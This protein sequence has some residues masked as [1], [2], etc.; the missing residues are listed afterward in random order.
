MLKSEQFED[1]IGS[2]SLMSYTHESSYNIDTAKHFQLIRLPL[3]QTFVTRMPGIT[4]CLAWQKEAPSPHATC[5]HL[6]PRVVIPI[7]FTT[8]TERLECSSSHLHA[9]HA[10]YCQRDRSV[11]Y[12]ILADHAAAPASAKPLSRARLRA[13]RS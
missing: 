1:Y 7:P 8:G 6:M 13:R 10:D 3:I 2:L 5:H 4:L 11:Q 9:F 12:S